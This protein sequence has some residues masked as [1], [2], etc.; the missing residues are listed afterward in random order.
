MHQPAQ[1]Q[2]QATS[3]R[4][5]KMRYVRFPS[6]CGCY[7]CGHLPAERRRNRAAALSGLVLVLVVIAQYIPLH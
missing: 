7:S 1:A 4:I 2:R 3:P 6:G 5:R